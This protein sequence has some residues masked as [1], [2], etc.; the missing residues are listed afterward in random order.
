MYQAGRSNEIF[1]KIGHGTDLRRSPYQGDDADTLLMDVDPSYYISLRLHPHQ[2][3]VKK[4]GEGVLYH[5]D[6][7]D[8]LLTDVDPSPA[9]ALQCSLQPLENTFHC[10]PLLPHFISHYLM[11]EYNTAVQDLFSSPPQSL[12]RAVEPGA[13]KFRS[14]W[15]TCPHSSP[16]WN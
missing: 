7:V 14:T 13:V 10:I 4:W 3:M 6:D 5:G 16:V 9:I 2:K 11:G 1:S 8:A 12:L 15:I